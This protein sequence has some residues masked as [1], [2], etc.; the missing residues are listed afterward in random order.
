MPKDFLAIIA[1]EHL[2]IK[3]DSAE[4]LIVLSI[5]IDCV[6]LFIFMSLIRAF[7]EAFVL[8]P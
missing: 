7:S 3:V 2:S 4:K 8:L 6:Q 5:V 1:S